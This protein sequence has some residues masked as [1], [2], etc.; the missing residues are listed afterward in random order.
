MSVGIP[1][2]FPSPIT[3]QTVEIN[4]LTWLL[5]LNALHLINLHDFLIFLFIL[6]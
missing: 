5:I 1:R 3:G 2:R 4:A 6:A